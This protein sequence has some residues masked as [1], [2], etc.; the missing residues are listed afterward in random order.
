ML[1]GV[2]MAPKLCTYFHD[3]LEGRTDSENSEDLQDTLANLRKLISKVDPND[4][5]AFCPPQLRTLLS[6]HHREQYFSK[7]ELKEQE[8]ILDHTT[9]RNNKPSELHYTIVCTLMVQKVTTFCFVRNSTLM[10]GPAIFSL[11][12][13][14]KPYSC[15][16][17]PQKG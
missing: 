13:L 3:R 2:P 6:K 12:T 10:L 7:E 15:P 8:V 14:F 9:L 5:W 11:F 17:N 4:K 16:K 1:G